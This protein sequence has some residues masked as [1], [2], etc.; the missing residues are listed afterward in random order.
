MLAGPLVPTPGYG[1]SAASSTITPMHAADSSA[2]VPPLTGAR[3]A[4]LLLRVARGE[5]ALAMAHAKLPLL[6]TAFNSTTLS[7]TPY[8]R[9]ISDAKELERESDVLSTS[10]FLVGS[11]I[12]AP[13]VG[14]STIVV[15]DGN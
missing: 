7:D 6:L 10:V 15:T 8:A 4:D 5:V 13:D 1:M 14:C 12:D 2:P 9:L 11:Y 3:A